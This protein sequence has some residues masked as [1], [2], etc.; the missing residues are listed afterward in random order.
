MNI[1]DYNQCVDKYADFV[2][3]FLL[4]LLRDEAIVKDL[5]QD[6]F[7]KLWRVHHDLDAEKAKP[8]LF[9]CAY[10]AMIDHTRR[11]RPTYDLEMSVNI[12]QHA[13][14]F[15]SLL[16]GELAARDLLTGKRCKLTL[17]AQEPA[18]VR[19]GAWSATIISIT[20][21]R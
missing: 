8:Y 4:K 10:N 12:P 20:N 15:L 9:R 2:Y 17:S 19:V 11:N 16:Q 3:R 18:L 6:S 5:V 21:N 14:D 7:E 1:T 13:F